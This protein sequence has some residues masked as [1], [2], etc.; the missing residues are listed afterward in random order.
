[1]FTAEVLQF[2]SPPVVMETLKA[3][4]FTDVPTFYVKLEDDDGQPRKFWFAEDCPLCEDCC[5]EKWEKAWCV[6]LHSLE[7][8][9][10]LVKTHLMSSS[11]HEV[12]DSFTAEHIAKEM[13]LY[14]EQM[15]SA[16]DR[17]KNRRILEVHEAQKQ[18]VAA[19]I[20]AKRRRE[21]EQNPT[22]GDD[23]SVGAARPKR[24][25]FVSKDL[26]ILS[27]ALSRAILASLHIGRACQTVADQ[28]R[29]EAGIF[30]KSLEMINHI[31]DNWEGSGSG[32]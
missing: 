7:H 21:Q 14:H 16:I 13:T 5:A 15:E 1:M 10:F 27:D 17:A 20:G 6:S 32:G 30:A 23:T 24:Q 9:Q 28:V 3:D 12:T 2:F 25:R 4:M 22:T 26:A 8:C 31:K 18:H 19:S 29:E 11:G